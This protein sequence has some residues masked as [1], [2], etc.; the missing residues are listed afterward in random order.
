MTNVHFLALTIGAAADRIEERRERKRGTR[1]K[2][3]RQDKTPT[4][5]R[6]LALEHR[7]GACR[8]DRFKDIIFLYLLYVASG[9]SG[10]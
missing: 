3:F 6:P 7:P 4:T 8:V 10:V 1:G 9:G 2:P 5:A